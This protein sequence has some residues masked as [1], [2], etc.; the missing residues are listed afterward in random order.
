M[1]PLH[2]V[3]CE[4]FIYLF[5]Y[6]WSSWWCLLREACRGV[7][8]WQCSPTRL[9]ERPPC[10]C[11]LV[12]SMPHLCPTLADCFNWHIGAR[13]STLWR[14]PWDKDPLMD[15]WLTSWL[16]G[17]IQ[18]RLKG[19]GRRG[20]L[21]AINLPLFSFFLS[22]SHRLI[23][24]RTF[25]KP[26]FRDPGFKAKLYFTKRKIPKSLARSLQGQRKKKIL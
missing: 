4:I 23:H 25:A 6:L 20:T 17:A 13:A 19:H 10:R 21:A 16:S 9:A 5:M 15:S 24:Q 18:G 22:P 26:Q 7:P 11:F 8:R 12:P 3:K 1:C 14:L 2:L